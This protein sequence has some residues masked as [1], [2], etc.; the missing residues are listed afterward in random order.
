MS[1]HVNYNYESVLFE[2]FQLLFCGEEYC[3]PNY[4]FGPAVRPNFVIHYILKGS[5]T[6]YVD[7]H[8]YHLNAGQGFVLFPEKQTTYKADSKTPWQYVWI[9]FKGNLAEAHLKH[10]GILSQF[11]IYSAENGHK[12]V[13]IIRKMLKIQVVDNKSQYVFQ[14][15]LLAFMSELS[16]HIKSDIKKD[17]QYEEHPLVGRTLNYIESNLDRPF[18]INDLSDSLFVNRS[19]LSRTF[20][21][22]KNISLKD[23]INNFRVT[24]AREM[25]SMTNVGLNEIA[26]QTGFTSYNSFYKTFKNIIRQTP[27]QYREDQYKLKINSQHEE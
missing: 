18:T 27:S 17:Q 10:V 6:F 8:S 22:E 9:G 14:S 5:G 7:N 11:P 16:L 13:E 2:D 24:R 4:Q 23:F 26:K 25:L 21:K 19:H 20:K 12:M 3:E 15:G 1:Y